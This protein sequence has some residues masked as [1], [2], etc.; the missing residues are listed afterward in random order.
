MNARMQTILRTNVAQAE[1]AFRR[2]NADS[3]IQSV[4]NYAEA[5]KELGLTSAGTLELLSTIR[6]QP[7]FLAAKGCGAMGADVI[8][9]VHQRS[10]EAEVKMWALARGLKICGDL[11]SLGP[12]LKVEQK[13]E[14]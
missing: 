12:G 7:W 10:H 1:Q 8:L 5:L 2:N 13:R 4:L 6:A 9:V 3:F 11:A 14:E